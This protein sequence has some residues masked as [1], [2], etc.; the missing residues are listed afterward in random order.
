MSRQ[1]NDAQNGVAR[2]RVSRGAWFALAALAG[3]A[4]AVNMK[5]RQVEREHP[6]AGRFIE[7]DGVRL[8]YVERGEGQ[9]LVLLHGNGITAEDFHL[10]GLLELAATSYRVIVFDRPGFG[11]SARPRGRLWTP[12]AQATLLQKAVQ[13]LGIDKPIVAGHSW[14]TQVAMSWA[15]DYPDKIK[16]LVLVS[17]YYYPSARLDAAVAS[18]PAIPLIGDLMRYTVSPLLSRMLWPLLVKRVFQPAAVTPQF[19]S[20]PA[21]MSLRPGQLRAS[22]AESALMVPAAARLSH[23]YR[24]LTV[25]AVIMAGEDDH[26]VD[27]WHQSVRLH[28]ELPTTE[29]RVVENAGHMLHHQVPQQVLAAIDSVAQKS[30]TRNVPSLAWPAVHAIQ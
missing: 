27:T 11:Y 2:M 19:A 21:W 1:M 7:V 26:I 8:H 29:L 20:Y 10:S 4:V 23:R 14:G 12:S 5:T 13:Q 30:Q 16:G 22:G 6:P 24:E 3:A 18:T 17:G 9:P 25:P 28:D 15:L